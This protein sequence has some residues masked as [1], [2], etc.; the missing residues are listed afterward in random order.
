MSVPVI[1]VV[2]K[3][4]TGKTTLLE[5][6]IVELK[7]R[8]Y[9]VGAMKHDAHQFDIDREG[10]DSWRLA[11]AG[12][13]TVVISS[14]EK[15]AMVKSNEEL[16]EPSLTD[17]VTSYFSDVDIV[18]TEGFKK[19]RVPKIEVHRKERSSTLMSRGE[20]HDTTLIAVASNEKLNVDVPLFD[21][22][23]FSGICDF[24]EERFLS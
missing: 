11:Q 1:S 17:V 15:L 12:A 18:L 9:R 24:I 5:K 23:D 22:N 20:E 8:G 7:R 3:S 4:G 6:L 19:S 10:K 2:A 13:D 16:K 21:I 14:P